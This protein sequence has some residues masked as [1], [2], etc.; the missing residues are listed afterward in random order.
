MKE[1][2]NKIGTQDQLLM[3]RYENSK[4]LLD[5]LMKVSKVPVYADNILKACLYNKTRVLE[6]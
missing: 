5:R 6:A 3:K 1:S 4:S 2:S